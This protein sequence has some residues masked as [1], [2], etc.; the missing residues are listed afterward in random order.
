MEQSNYNVKLNYSLQTA[1]K[2]NREKQQHKDISNV[3]QK[4]TWEKKDS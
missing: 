2:E 3:W 4:E 1:G